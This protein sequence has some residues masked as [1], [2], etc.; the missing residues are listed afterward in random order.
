M[1]EPRASGSARKLGGAQKSD[2]NVAKGPK[3]HLEVL[4]LPKLGTMRALIYLN[5]VINYKRQNQRD[6][7]ERE[8]EQM[9]KQIG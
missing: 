4:S 8:K 7:E 6:R 5:M 3:S 1:G 2:G 9:I